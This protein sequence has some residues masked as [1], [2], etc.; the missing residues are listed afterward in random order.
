ME[1]GSPCRMSIIRYGNVALSNLRK[2]PVALSNLRKGPVAGHLV[3]EKAV[4][5]C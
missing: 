1:G 2:A 3:L 4:S 5:P